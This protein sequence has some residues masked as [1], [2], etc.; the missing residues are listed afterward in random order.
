MD[1]AGASTP[2]RPAI[3][4]TVPLTASETRLCEATIEKLRS[5]QGAR[6]RT[7]VHLPEEDIIT[8][9]RAART[10]F[11]SQSPLLEVSPPISICGDIHGQFH[12]LLRIFEMN[13]FPGEP[14]TEGGYLFLGDYVDRAKQSIETI[15]LL[16]CYKLIYQETF[17]LLRGNHEC[18]TLNRI[19]GFFDECKRRYNVRLWRIFG[20]CF[21][22]M[23]VAAVVGDKIFC[24]H[25]GLSPE[26][27]S[28]SRIHEI[29]RPTEVADEGLLCDLLWADPDPSIRGWGNNLRGVSYTFG[30]DVVADFLAKHDL[31]LICRAHQVVEDG[32][33]F[34]ADRQL[35]TI[36]S[37]PNYCGEFDNAGG[38]LVVRKNMNCSFR[39]LRP[40]S[41][42][43][44]K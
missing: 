14:T 40:S 10:V 1:D 24:T 6:P 43:T 3:V 21:N 19:Y 7:E 17:F 42:E 2:P 34:Q 20:D 33:E 22:C 16:L 39:I 44:R 30:H 36:F 4:Q 27:E 13:G 35:V 8:I 23:P 15:C 28:L 25:G 37:A 41:H 38:I 29:K 12:D 31:D 26:L 11:L 18:S 5:L 9:C 32:Y